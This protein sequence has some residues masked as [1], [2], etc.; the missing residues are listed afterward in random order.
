MYI[1]DCGYGRSRKCRKR[2]LL[3]VGAFILALSLS[4]VTI[5]VMAGERW[6]LQEENKKTKEMTKGTIPIAAETVDTEPVIMEADKTLIMVDPGH[7]GVDNG[8]SRSGVEESQINLEIGMALRDT[9]VEMGYE[10]LMTRETD[11]AV[12]LEER[13][14]LANDAGAD[15][16]I[17]IHQNA[18]EKS[19]VSGIETWYNSSTNYGTESKRLA[20][21]IHNDVILF[22]D[23][24][25]RGIVDNST[26]YVIREAN[27]PSCLIETGFLSN[28]EERSNL[29]NKEYQNKIVNGIASGV[30]LYFHPKTMYL[31]F[32]DGPSSE[33]TEAILD[34]L[35][36][37]NIKATFFVIGENV[38]KNPEIA[39]RIVEEGHTIGIHCDWHDYNQLYADVESYLADFENARRTV[40]E[41]TGV[42]AV[43]FRFPGGSINAYNKKVYK[44][45]IE[46]MINKGY[47]YYDWNASLE[48]A[49]SK[50]SPE[51]LLLN[52]KESTLGRKKV[53]MLAHDTVE[54]T[55]LCLERLLE[56]FPEYEMKPLTVDVDPI[57][58]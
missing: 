4:G 15:L 53:I 51:Q 34:I 36:E 29:T 43:I 40:C 9:L 6:E 37:Y 54:N 17:S 47:V 19:N 3:V 8:C 22:T 50:G 18:C 7:G 2:V 16:Y 39:R 10:V 48:D 23:E 30:D 12:T 33:N 26:L 31:T 20:Q 21:L 32:D 13:V 38:R 27:M 44:D 49:V 55:V 24:I 1:K 58:F 41:V 14:K 46:E 25:D 57:Q 35:K 45:I 11:V 56:Q 52:A 28:A 42:E 5:H